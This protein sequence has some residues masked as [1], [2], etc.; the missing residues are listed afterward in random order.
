V[1]Y[2]VYTPSITINYTP[3]VQDPDCQFP[4]NCVVNRRNE[5]FGTYEALPTWITHT[6]GSFTIQTDDPNAVDVYSLSIVCSI[7]L[8]QQSPLLQSE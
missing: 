3:H 5:D 6:S 2:N 8:A 7:P 4:L 1:L